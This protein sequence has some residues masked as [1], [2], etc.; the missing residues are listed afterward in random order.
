MKQK[1]K[2]QKKLTSGRRHTA[3]AAKETPSSCL[4]DENGDGALKDGLSS[5]SRVLFHHR[6]HAHVFQ[7]HFL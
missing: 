3:A 5:L 4:L 1:Q 2:Q 6:F 7:S